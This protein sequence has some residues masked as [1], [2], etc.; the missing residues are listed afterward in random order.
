METMQK[1]VAKNI[2]KLRESKGLSMENLAKLSGVSKS[3]LAQIERG[4]GNPT[5]STLWKIANGMGVAFDALTARPEENYE[6]VKIQE[7]QP[8]LEDEGRVKNYSIF[9]DNG[10][11]KF[12]VYYLELEKGSYWKSEAHLK[13][14]TELITVFQGKI[15]IQV[16]GHEFR[17]EE[18]QSIRFLADVAHAYKNI[19][20]GTAVLHM[21]LYEAL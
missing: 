18:T 14:T 1:I 11:R 7:M 15:A 19:G 17:I 3:M 20:D 10:S 8:L 2:K 6:L 4:E 9:P 12:A 13:G 21:I 5:L 16:D